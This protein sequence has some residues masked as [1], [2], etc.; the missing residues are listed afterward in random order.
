M[1]NNQSSNSADRPHGLPKF[2]SDL[3]RREL[4]QTRERIG[5]GGRT[6][7]WEGASPADTMQDTLQGRPQGGSVKRQLPL[8]PKSFTVPDWLIQQ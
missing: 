2:F 4:T 6:L 3:G 1:A 5:S 7:R 8:D